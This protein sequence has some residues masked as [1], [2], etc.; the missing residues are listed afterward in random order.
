MG[1]Q[2]LREADAWWEA[3]SRELHRYRCWAM[4]FIARQYALHQ[5]DAHYGKAEVVAQAAKLIAARNVAHDV[6]LTATEGMRTH[7][8]CAIACEG[9]ARIYFEDHEGRAA[10]EEHTDHE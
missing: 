5:L 9:M 8:A 4:V 6:M 10:R 1:Q 2:K 3:W 7:A